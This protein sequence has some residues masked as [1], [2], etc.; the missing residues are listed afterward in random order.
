M[1]S[2]AKI[3]SQFLGENCFISNMSGIDQQFIHYIHPFAISLYL[4]MIT[5]LARRSYRLSS[6][7]SKGIIHVMCCLLL[8]SYTSLAITSL[9]L[10]R[11]LVFHD[12]DKVYTYVSPDV[13]YFH[14]RHLVYAIVAVLFTI[15]IVIGLPLLLALEPFLNFK[16]NF[17]RIKPLLDQFQGCYKDKYRCFAAYYMVCRLIIIT[18]IIANSSNEYIFQYLLA[19]TCVM[20]DLTHQIFKPYSNSLLNNFDGV[21][22]YF[23]VLVSMLPLAEIHNSFNSNLA[24]G[25]IFIYVASPLLIFITISLIIN[26]EQ[27]KSLPE[28][29]YLKCLQLHLRYH[30]CNELPLSETPLIK[31]EESSNEDE[32]I[33][34]IDD[35]KRKNA[36]VCEM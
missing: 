36:T 14:G 1:S 32:Y 8:L 7:I 26:K 29:C 18:V 25:I 20:M 5:M 13:E 24:A 6:F 34:V 23:L 4:V 17:I 16:I 27:I 21:I 35:N 2:F 12:V 22:L 15:V 30:K 3:I 33:N 9:L 28:C 31:A 10:M 11:P 19:S